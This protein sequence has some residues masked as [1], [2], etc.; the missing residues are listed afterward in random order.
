MPKGLFIFSLL[1]GKSNSRLLLNHLL[2]NA[3]KFSDR[4]I[5]QGLEVNIVLY[6]F[7]G[8]VNQFI[9]FFRLFF[10]IESSVMNGFLL[11]LL[12]QI[13]CLFIPFENR[14]PQRGGY[15][16]HAVTFITAVLRLSFSLPTLNN[17]L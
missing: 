2:M 10:K 16:N 8:I 13:F 9:Q 3:L 14:F 6:L 17:R 15:I 1:L 4:I 12:R 5:N 11:R 7:Q